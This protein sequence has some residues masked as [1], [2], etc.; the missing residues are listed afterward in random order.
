MAGI[1]VVKCVPG[2]VGW[3]QIGRELNSREIAREGLGEGA[4]QQG[5]AQAGNAFDEHVTGGNQCGE[6]LVDRFV[7]TDYR[8]ADFGAHCASNFA[9]VFELLLGYIHGFRPQ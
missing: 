5:L 2:H 7:L 9:C 6:N 3:H 8:F 4:H 1:L